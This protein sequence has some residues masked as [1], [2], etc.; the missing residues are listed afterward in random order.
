M[1]TM[2]FYDCGA[3]LSRI[4]GCDSSRG[5]SILRKEITISSREGLNGA[6]MPIS[7]IGCKVGSVV[8]PL[9]QPE[10]SLEAIYLGFP[11][12][13]HPQSLLDWSMSL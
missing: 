3:L 8:T 2:M 9:E 4:S 11:E 13:S 1:G 7:A 6:S 12:K 10:N 5:T